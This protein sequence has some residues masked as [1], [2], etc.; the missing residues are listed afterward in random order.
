MVAVIQ[1]SRKDFFKVGSNNDL[2]M[3]WVFGGSNLIVDEDL[4][5]AIGIFTCEFNFPSG[6]KTV[7]SQE[8]AILRV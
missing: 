5:W 6:F 1:H 7:D 4:G 8:V 3:S 2:T